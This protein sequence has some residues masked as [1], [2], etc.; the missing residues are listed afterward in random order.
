[1]MNMG[2]RDN[3]WMPVEEKYPHGTQTMPR[4]RYGDFIPRQI[5]PALRRQET[6]PTPVCQR[7]QR[8][9][10]RSKWRLDASLQFWR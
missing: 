8:F 10:Q 6:T 1:M 4:V 5:L 3:C 7:R 2:I 9:S